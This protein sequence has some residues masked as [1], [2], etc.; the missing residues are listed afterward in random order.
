MD[1]LQNR[2]GFLATQARLPRYYWGGNR[3]LVDRLAKL[4][5]SKSARNDYGPLCAF[6]GGLPGSL[7]GRSKLPLR[8]RAVR[9]TST[10]VIPSSP[11]E[12]LIGSARESMI[13]HCRDQ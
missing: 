9:W 11:I 4:I 13:A 5:C 10:S 2:R 8:S 6:A 12:K 3:R 1:I 7:S